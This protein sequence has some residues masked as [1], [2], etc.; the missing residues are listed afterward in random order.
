MLTVV[1]G[2]LRITS[3]VVG[4]LVTWS[5]AVTSVT[6]V[7]APLRPAWELSLACVCVAPWTLLYFSGIADLTPVAHRARFLWVGAVGVM[8][9]VYYC[10]VH[11]SMSVFT[12][13]VMPLLAVALGVLPLFVRRFRFLFV[14]ASVAVGVTGILLIYLLTSMLWSVPDTTSDLRVGKP[15][16]VEI[17]LS[18]VFSIALIAA[19][20]LSVWGIQSRSNDAL[21]A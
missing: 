10:D 14:V 20:V 8:S 7:E 4:L 19:G 2:F 3:A 15:G 21:S 16:A 18:L 6:G 5:F 12:K 17:L 13:T 11:T 9:L 1:R